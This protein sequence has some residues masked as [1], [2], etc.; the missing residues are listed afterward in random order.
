MQSEVVRWIRGY[1]R[2]EVQ[3]K[4]GAELINRALAQGF[5]LWDIRVSGE[6]KVQISIPGRDALRLRPLLK[7]TGC[8]IHVQKREGLPFAARKWSKRKT[9]AIGAVLFVAALYFLSSFVWNVKVEG[10]VSIRTQAIL[11]AA[12]QEGLY[13]YQWK[14]RMPDSEKLSYQLQTRLEGTSWVGVEINGTQVTIK[15]V[16]ADKPEEKPLVS[17]RNLVA[18]KHAVVTEIQAKRGRPLVQP[19]TYVRKGDVLISGTLGDETHQSIVVADGYVKGIVWYV[20]KIEVP[21][22]QTYQT[23]TGE[24]KTRRYLVLGSQGIQVSGY[25]KLPFQQYV[26]VPEHTTLQWRTFKLP[27]GWLSEKLLASETVERQM[28]PAEAKGMGLEQA[29]ADILSEGGRE[30]RIVSEKILHEKTENG[31]VYMEVHFEVEEFIMQEQ[32]IVKQGE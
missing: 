31:K 19:N 6:D 10:N 9:F 7:E 15:V 30:A 13:P 16:E 21:L 22:V 5:A 14:P 25:G 24:S 8:R 12:K 1:V 11:D 26:T 18:G 32:P 3:G 29:R 2:L 23:Y 4:S 17:P 28:E 20:S 27:V